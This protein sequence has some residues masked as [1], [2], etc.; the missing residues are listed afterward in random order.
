MTA[1]V[2][3]LP[4]QSAEMAVVAAAVD[5][6]AQDLVVGNAQV[7]DDVTVDKLVD[8]DKALVDEVLAL[9]RSQQ[10]AASLALGYGERVIDAPIVVSRSAMEEWPRS[11]MSPGSTTVVPSAARP[12]SIR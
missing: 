12:A 10:H 9:V 1:R 3:H 11:I 4:R 6:A 2:H 8:G 5:L 7:G